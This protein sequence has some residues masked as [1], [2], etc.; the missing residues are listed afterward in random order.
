MSNV[1]YF[2]L[3]RKNLG[4]DPVRK[5]IRLAREKLGQTVDEDDSDYYDQ[6]DCIEEVAELEE[7]PQDVHDEGDISEYRAWQY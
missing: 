6:D 2:F 3:H 1:T 5:L 4:R 7:E